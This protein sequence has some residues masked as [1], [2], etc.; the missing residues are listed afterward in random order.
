MDL[1]RVEILRGPQGTLSGM[2]ALGG[3]IKLYSKKP[4]GD[5]GGFVEGTARRAPV[6]N[7][8]SARQPLSASANS[9][10]LA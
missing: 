2:N 10:A 6:L 8:D 5:N 1:D 9:T 3:A 7:S 4:N